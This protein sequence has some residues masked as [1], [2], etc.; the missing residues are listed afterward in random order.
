MEE[1]YKQLASH[2][3]EGEEKEALELVQQWKEE[4]SL[5]EVHEDIITPAMYHVG[6]LW[7]KNEIT[8]A[9]EHLAT[10]ICDYI[11]T[12]LSPRTSETNGRKAIFFNV[13]EEQHHLG[14]KMAA[15]LFREQGWDAR[16][17]GAGMPN[18]HV[19]SQIEKYQ[20]D[21]VCVSASLSYRVPALKE[22]I[23]IIEETVPGS[24]ILVG[25]RIVQKY[26]MKEWNTSRVD[27]LGSLAEIKGWLNK[28]KE[29][30]FD[31]TS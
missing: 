21:V 29:G 20:P 27:T 10:A 26:G 13:E 2:L 15:D 18:D 1:V 9:D 22:I 8:V 23:R 12:L 31:E 6:E 17:L 30:T 16:F 14:L 4:R 19:L 25:G 5:T 3:L 24:Y 28:E 7:Q 11:L